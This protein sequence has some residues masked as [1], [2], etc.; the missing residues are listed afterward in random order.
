MVHIGSNEFQLPPGEEGRVL[1]LLRSSLKQKRSSKH[2][3]DGDFSTD[4]DHK[5]VIIEEG[6]EEEDDD[7][8]E[9]DDDDDFLVPT[10]FGI[11]LSSIYVLFVFVID[12]SIGFVFE[13]SSQISQ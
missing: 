12:A 7:D 13:R 8:E 10:K 6:Q 5:A 4:D 3:D 2:E 9:E 1:A 11:F